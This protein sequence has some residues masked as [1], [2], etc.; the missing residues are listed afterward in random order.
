[1]GASIIITGVGAVIGQGIVKSLLGR[2]LGL[3]LVGI[4][5]NPYSVGFY[6]TDAS[7]IVPRVDDPKWLSS[8]TDI[9]NRE[10]VALI[11]PGIEQDVKAL[12][13]HV[14]EIR[15]RTN[16]VPLLNSPQSL[17][18]GFDKWELYLFAKAHGVKT[19]PTWFLN[20]REIDVLNSHQY[21]LLL[22]PR[23]GMAGKGIQKIENGTELRFWI[24][25]LPIDE[26]ILQQSVGTDNEEY[27][28]SIFGFKGNRLSEPFALRRRLNYGSTFEAETIV[29]PAL[30]SEVIRIAKKLKIIGPTNLQFRKVGSEYYLIEINPRF[31]SSTSIKSGFGFNE[32]LMAVKNFL[33]DEVEIHLTLKTGRC[34]RYIEDF[35]QFE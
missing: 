30:S 33:Y 6:W 31:S 22:K 24:E 16:S 27:T 12:S 28:V 3:R 7:Y 13:S 32:P 26:Y 19:P 1:M 25:R 18:V 23:K 5:A 9:C 20:Q 10:E 21:P 14:E 11:L 29:D 17:K 8:I 34:S 4:D 2:N 15:K 35:I